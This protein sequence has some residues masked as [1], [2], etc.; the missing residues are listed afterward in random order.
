MADTAIDAPAPVDTL[1]ETAIDAPAPAKKIK[2]LKTATQVEADR[3][4]AARHGQRDIPTA[5]PVKFQGIVAI[6][7]L[8]L[9]VGMVGGMIYLGIQ[10][11]NPTVVDDTPEGYDNTAV[12]VR[13]FPAVAGTIKVT[14]PVVY[15]IDT[16]RPMGEVFE[17]AGN[18]VIASAKSLKGGKFNVILLGEDEDKALSPQPITSDPAGIAKAKTFIALEL[19]GAAEQARGMQAA[20]DMKAKTVVLLARDSAMGA[21]DLAQGA[22]KEKAVKLHTIVLGRTSRGLAQMAEVTGGETKKFT[23]SE[24]AEQAKRAAGQ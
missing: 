21:K 4:L 5:A 22:F 11:T 19:C 23:T 18:I 16:S 7:L 15:L 14:A 8:V 17:A 12:T 24:L 20:L 1:A 3:A 9:M 6:I 13:E 10:I 2:P